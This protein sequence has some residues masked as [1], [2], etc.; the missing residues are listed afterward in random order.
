MAEKMRMYLAGE[1]KD[2]DKSIE[3]IN[4]Y[5][6]SIYGTVAAASPDDFTEAIAR[7][8]EVFNEYRFYPSYKRSEALQFI[9]SEIERR[10]D[11]FAETITCEMGK[12]L[13]DSLGEVGRAVSVFAI[14]AEEAKR[15][16]G[17]VMSLDWAAGSENRW[18]IIR[19]FPM[20]VVA[21][22]SPFNFPLNLIAHKIGPALASGN[23]IVLK[24]ASKTPITALKLAEIIDK[25]DLPK[26]ICSILPASSKDTTPLIEDPRVKVITFTGSPVVGWKIKAISGKKRVVLELGGNAGVIVADDADIDYAVERIVFGG[27]AVSGQSCISVQRVFLHESIYDEFIRGFAERVSNLIVGNPLDSGVNVGPVVE[28]NE[29]V[30][31]EE[32]INE[33]VA[34]GAK[35][36]AGGKREGGA[37]LPTILTNVNPDM[38][39]CAME[40]FAPLVTVFKYTDFKSAVDKINNSDFGLQ[41]GIF[42]N[43][44]KDI[45]YAYE[46]IETGGVVI[47][48][49]PTYRADHQPYGGMK[50]SGFGRE[51]IRY[52]IEDY[53]EIKILSMNLK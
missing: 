13:A 49:V 45:W 2:S 21:G 44:M 1:W 35:V 14:S 52:S 15:M 6:K 28:E 7:A 18:G 50:D 4:P 37:V 27:F 40:V 9:A 17:E 20:G 19:R 53:T 46:R 25:T 23:T 43:R 32:W 34:G 31:I 36:L 33:A 22:I 24:P 26:G 47:N 11:E 42:T 51:G 12:S 8:D 29:A 41:A 5:N 39:V 10:K 48:D 3:V 38:K 16:G 30:R